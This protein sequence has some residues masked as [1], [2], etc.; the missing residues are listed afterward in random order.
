MMA[1]QI[2]GLVL[3]KRKQFMSISPGIRYETDK[4]F[5]WHNLLATPDLR[6]NFVGLYN[7]RRRRTLSKFSKELEVVKTSS[8]RLKELLC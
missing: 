2:G 3:E 1:V 6:F 8:M 7:T 4:E 5:D